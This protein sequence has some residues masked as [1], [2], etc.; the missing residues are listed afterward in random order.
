MYTKTSQLK[1][2]KTSKVCLQCS[3]K[4]AI[5]F[6]E[7]PTSHKCKDCLSKNKRLKKF[8]GKEKTRL[9]NE[10]WELTKKYIRQRDKNTCQWCGKKITSVY[11]SHTSHVKSKKLYP[12]LKFD[13]MNLKLLCY[14]CHIQK[15]HKDPDDAITWFKGKF[16]KRWK[17][18]QQHKDDVKKLSKDDLRE[19]INEYL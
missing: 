19:L 6:F 13:S 12:N 14:H 18:I 7:K 15:W 17:Y 5:R 2:T 10:L 11:D 3:R 9:K 16:S 8:S 1:R 4:R